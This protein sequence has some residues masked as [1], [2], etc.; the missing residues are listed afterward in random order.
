MQVYFVLLS[1]NTTGCVVYKYYRFI[2]NLVV[3][4]EKF[5]SHHL[6][7]AVWMSQD[8]WAELILFD[9]NTIYLNTVTIAIKF[10]CG[11]LEDIQIPPLF[12]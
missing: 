9:R 2:W 5:G 3:K 6:A 4:T 10:Q 11:F 8:K 7:R 1:W 12:L